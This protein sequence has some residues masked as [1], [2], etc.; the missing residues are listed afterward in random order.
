VAYLADH[1][2]EVVT[3]RAEGVDVRG[4]LAW[5][6]FDNIEWAQGWSQRFGIVHV[7]Q[8]TQ[9]R[10]PKASAHWLRGLQG[11]RRR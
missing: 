1:L 7:D 11:R 8:D 6:L 9:V 10:T 5:S 2:A 3:A 4:Y